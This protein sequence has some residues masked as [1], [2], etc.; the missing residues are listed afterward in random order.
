MYIHTY[1]LPL[2][3]ACLLYYKLTQAEEKV[4]AFNLNT[5]LTFHCV[6]INDVHYIT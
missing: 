2:N 6:P 1:T 4:V 5:L 3:S